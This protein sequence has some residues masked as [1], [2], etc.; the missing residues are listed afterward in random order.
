MT[1]ALASAFNHP[2]PSARLNAALRA[3]MRPSPEDVDV[4][5]QQCRAEPDFQ[6]REMLT[7]ALIRQPAK[8]V[9]PTL[10]DD[11][12]RPEPQ[13]RSQA[14]HTL[15]KVKDASAWPAVAFG[16]DDPE[17]DVVRTA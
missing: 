2:D 6:V 12:A 13:A 4:L 7:W 10:V 8:T 15:S 17:P 11:L 1:S 3:G 9:V 16:L 14:L 5:V